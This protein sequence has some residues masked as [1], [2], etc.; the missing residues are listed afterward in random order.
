VAA[1]DALPTE[2]IQLAEESLRRCAGD[3]FF[4][5]F[6]RRLLSVDAATRDKFAQ[7]DFSRQNKVLQHGLGLLFTYAKHGN[8]ALLDRIATRHDQRDLDIAPSYYPHFVESLLHSVREF[9]PQLSPEVEDAWKRSMAPG[10][11]F[12]VDRYVPPSAGGA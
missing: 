5:A 2:T 6:Y 3:A 9:D 7:T 4:Q 12:I 1:F 8:P 11:A 10:I